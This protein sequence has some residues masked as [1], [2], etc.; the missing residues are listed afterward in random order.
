[1]KIAI[2]GIRGIPANYGGFETFAEQLS[3][4][5]AQ[6]GH[7]VTV[8]CRTNSIKYK[9][10]YYKGVKLI[11]LPTVKHKYFDTVAHTFLCVLQSLICNYDVI[12][13]CNSANSLFSFIP[14]IAGS[15]VV[16]NVDGLEW[17]RKK[18][19]IFGKYFYRIS[20]YF[21]TIFPNKIVSDAKVVQNYYKKKFKE[22][23]VYIPYGALTEKISSKEILKKYNLEANKYVL[24]V[25]RLEPENNAHLVVK[26]FEKV[27]TDLQ[28]VI[29]GDAPYNSQYITA[30]KNTKDPRIIF[31]GYVFGQSY[32]EFQSNAYIYIQATEVGGTHP[33]LLEGMGFGNCVL[34]NDVPEHHEV[35]DETGLYFYLKKDDDLTIKMQYLSDNPE[36]VTKYKVKTVKRVKD[37]YTWDKVV[38]DYERLF[39]RLNDSN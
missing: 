22:I 12:L 20:E 9:P 5:L 17:Q 28:L 23:S 3:V 24:Y 27:K 35:L 31:T 18:W 8:Y 2:M 15:K 29:I 21:A 26:A 34:A 25:S 19:N 13:I 30:L 36:V 38:D 10:K 33:A 39:R 11:K 16:L 1:M 37:F 7:E 4:R 14:R 6:K 32:K